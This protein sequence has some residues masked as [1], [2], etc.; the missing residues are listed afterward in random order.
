M[1]SGAVAYSIAMLACFTLVWG[2]IWLIAKRRDR[3]RGILM[4]V[5]AV[6]L[7]GNVL[8][9]VMPVG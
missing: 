7:L 5:A 2:G 9:W 6:V 4:L 8:V 1:I 3:K